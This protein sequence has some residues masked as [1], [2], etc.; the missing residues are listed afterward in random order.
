MPV[1]PDA[2][3]ARMCRWKVSLPPRMARESIYDILSEQMMYY[4]SYAT[5]KKSVMV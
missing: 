1:F 5:E 2:S 4:S 3:Q